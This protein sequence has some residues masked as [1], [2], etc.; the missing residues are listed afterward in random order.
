MVESSKLLPVQKRGTIKI[1]FLSS[2]AKTA[3]TSALDSGI[4]QTKVAEMF[5][6]MENNFRG[7]RI[8]QNCGK[9]IITNL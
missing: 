4:F 6:L 2:L 8:I 5:F 3:F 7:E 9:T 1:D